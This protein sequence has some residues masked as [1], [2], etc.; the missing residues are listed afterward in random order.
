MSISPFVG[1]CLF[2]LGCSSL[3]G[4]EKGAR[5]E[6]MSDDPEVREQFARGL[7]LHQEG[8]A[9]DEDAVVEA[10]EIM[11][12]LLAANPDDARV[13]VFLGNLYV[14]RA[15]DAVFYKKMDWLKKGVAVLDEAVAAAPEDPDVRSVRAINSYQLPRIFGRRDI[16][17]EDFEVLV[18]WAETD[19]DRYSDSLL[20]FVYYHAGIFAEKVG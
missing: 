9:G 4:L 5:P 2:V 11:E 8:V 1:I 3:W 7:D 17:E 20:R 18:N 16:A 19:P 10:Q 6:P 14:L 13:Q 15:R 12:E